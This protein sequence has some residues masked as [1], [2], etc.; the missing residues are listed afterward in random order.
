[1]K[2]YCNRTNFTNQY[3]NLV[4]ILSKLYNVDGLN[5]LIGG[6]MSS[7]EA[8]FGRRSFICAAGLTALSLIGLV[9]P[10]IAKAA[11][12]HGDFTLAG[13]QTRCVAGINTGS[14]S[15][16]GYAQTVVDGYVTAGY[17]GA[18]VVVYNDAGS[19]IGSNLTYSGSNGNSHTTY[20][21]VSATPGRSYR[22]LAYSYVF[23]NST[24]SYDSN[25]N[26]VWSPYQ[27]AYNSDE[28]TYGTNDLGLSYGP[29]TGLATYGF[30]PDLI[31]A[32]GKNG[33][34]GYVYKNDFMPPAPVNPEDALSNY[35]TQQVNTVPVYDVDGITEID[36]FEVRYGG[37]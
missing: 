15:A 16:T 30:L 36:V 26:P 17:L 9:R 37:N 7:K 24:G 33:A 29:I 34:V 18:Y 32:D 13:L 6:L 11:V 1:M 3:Y 21:L 25:W 12:G 23:N 4:I 35:A 14:G 5:L 31:M 20:C 28:C 8:L 10:E 19:S 2:F 27:T 22:S